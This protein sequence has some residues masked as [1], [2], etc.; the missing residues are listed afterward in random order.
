[1]I[2][3]QL[4]ESNVLLAAV[5]NSPWTDVCHICYNTGMICHG[6]PQSTFHSMGVQIIMITTIMLEGR[7]TAT[8]LQSSPTVTLYMELT[9]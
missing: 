9:R 2:N 8:L 6:V 4:M 3:Q 7:A 5:C 1:M